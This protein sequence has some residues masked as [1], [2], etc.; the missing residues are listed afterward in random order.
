MYDWRE[1]L[2]VSKNKAPPRESL[3]CVGPIPRPAVVRVGRCRL[4]DFSHS[5]PLLFPHLHLRL[6]GPG[7]HV[8]HVSFL[9]F[10]AVPVRSPLPILD[11]LFA[12]TPAP[13]SPAAAPR[14]ALVARLAQ[15]ALHVI[16]LRLRTVLHGVHLNAVAV[17]TA[18]AL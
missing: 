1:S 16:V 17:V 2:T 7:A 14:G 12:K 10:R 15:P 4:L 3:T 11:G 6:S 8:R 5:S 18:G 9:A 13:G